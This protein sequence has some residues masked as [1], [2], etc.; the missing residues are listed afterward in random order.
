ML[1]LACG[2]HRGI[3]PA[4]LGWLGPALL[5]AVGCEL[6]TA[7]AFPLARDTTGEI[8][9]PGLHRVDGLLFCGSTLA[10]LVLSRRLA[11]DPS[12]K[13]AIGVHAGRRRPLLREHHGAPPAGAS[14]IRAAP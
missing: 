11:A 4:R 7:A 6:F 10:F 3:E 14:D 2:R 5:M 8:Y 1:L 9:D 12:V 13:I